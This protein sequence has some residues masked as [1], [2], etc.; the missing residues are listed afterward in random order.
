MIRPSSRPVWTGRTDSLLKG[1]GK[2]IG[3]AREHARRQRRAS[4]CETGPSRTGIPGVAERRPPFYPERRNTRCN[5]FFLAHKSIEFV[6]RSCLRRCAGNIYDRKRYGSMKAIS[7]NDRR[8]K[9]RKAH[10]MFA[11]PIQPYRPQHLTGP[12]GAISTFHRYLNMSALAVAL[13]VAVAL[14]AALAPT[15]AA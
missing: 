11:S 7:S 14:L 13:F 12:G 2:E 15:R 6:R 5:L 8:I 1:E 4:S 9:H 3:G 10:H